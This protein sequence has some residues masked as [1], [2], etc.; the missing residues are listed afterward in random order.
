MT[1]AD[2]LSWQDPWAWPEYRRLHRRQR[3]ATFLIVVA[4]IGFVPAV[5]IILMPNDPLLRP[6]LT[7]PWAWAGLLLCAFFTI[8]SQRMARQ[9]RARFD[10]ALYKLSQ[11]T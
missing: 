10:F 6:D 2:R 5:W 11:L 3:L 1:G 7:T 9:A 8:A 4:I